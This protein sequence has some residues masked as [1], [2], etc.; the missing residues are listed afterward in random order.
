MFAGV[1]SDSRTCPFRHDFSPD[2]RKQLSEYFVFAD[3][4]QQRAAAARVAAVHGRSAREP[5][6]GIQDPH[7][8]NAYMLHIAEAPSHAYEQ[9]HAENGIEVEEI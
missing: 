8:Q 4:R 1:C 2:E 6:H 7:I 5:C 3:E 9:M